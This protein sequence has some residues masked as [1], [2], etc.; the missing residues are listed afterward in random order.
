MNLFRLFGDMSHLASIFILLQKIQTSRSCRGISFKTQVLYVV[1]FV[2]RYLDLFYEWV[3][4]YN[5]FMKVFFIASSCYVLYLMKVKFRPTNDPSIDTFR[6]EYLVGPCVIFALIF[7]YHFTIPEVLWS[8]SI[9]LES[10]AILPQLFMLQRTGEAE[11]ITTHYLAA[12][13]AYRALYIPNWIYRYF[14]EDL[15]DP[16]AVTAGLVQTGLYLDFFYVY[17]TKVLQGQKFELP[18]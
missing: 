8:F 3:S 12:L 17:V 9:F 18:A 2:S 16:I 7:H 11:T 15:V 5:F 1:V 13:G 10:V 6:V 14:T 4:V